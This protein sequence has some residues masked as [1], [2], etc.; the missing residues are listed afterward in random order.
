[1][2]RQIQPRTRREYKLFIYDL[3]ERAGKE[4][5]LCGRVGGRLAR[6]G[7]SPRVYPLYMQPSFPRES[8]RAMRFLRVFASRIY[9]NS[10]FVSVPFA[11]HG[12]VIIFEWITVTV[13]L[14][15]NWVPM[16]PAS[17]VRYRIVSSK[18]NESMKHLLP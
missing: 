11:P 5:G 4:S 7:L 6:L 3:Y 18:I 16:H 14:G 15:R 17:Q 9:T 12:V 10:I 8:M 1:M 2:Q 13:D